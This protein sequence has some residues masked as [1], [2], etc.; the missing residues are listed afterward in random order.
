VL[1]IRRKTADRIVYILH[2][3]CLLNHVTEGKI[4]GSIEVTG[5]WGRRCKR[6]LDNLKENGRYCKEEAL[7]HFLW[8]TG[9]EGFIDL[10][11]DRKEFGRFFLGW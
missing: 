4:E 11:K 9:F 1:T 2:R 3:N 5:R 7:D 8:R 6:L 10:S